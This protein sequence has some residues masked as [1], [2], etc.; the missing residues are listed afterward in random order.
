M[1]DKMQKIIT[2]FRKL[3]MFLERLFNLKNKVVAVIGGG[4]YLCSGMACHLLTQGVLLL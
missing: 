2:D 4:G 1:A 3:N